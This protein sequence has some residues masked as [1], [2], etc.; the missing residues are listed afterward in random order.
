MADFWTS[1]N[2]EPKRKYRFLVQFGGGAGGDVGNLWFAKSVTKPEITIGSTEH[3][4]MNHK[5]YY[6]GTI[7]WNEIT[8]TLVDPV[9]PDAAAMTGKMLKDSGYTGP[10]QLKDGNPKTL[11]KAGSVAALGGVTITVV[12]QKGEPLETWTLKN[13]FIIKV[14]YGDLA[15][16]EDELTEI[17]LS[18][19]YDWAEM[20]VKGGKKYF[21]S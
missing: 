5:F 18:F 3:S 8:L 11:S 6:P 12:D 20:D 16:G 7:E 17:E 2:V 10:G 4:Y 1:A 21:G 13:A 14:G 9:T 19:R 15:Y